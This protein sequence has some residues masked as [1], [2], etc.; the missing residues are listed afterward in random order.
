MPAHYLCGKNK[1][2]ITGRI[3][4]YYGFLKSKE[5][6]EKNYDLRGREEEEETIFCQLKNPHEAG[7]RLSLAGDICGVL[8]LGTYGQGF[9]ENFLFWKKE[10]SCMEVLA[11]PFQAVTFTPAWQRC[12]LPHVPTQHG[13]VYFRGYP[14]HLGTG[15]FPYQALKR[16][17]EW[18]HSTAS[19]LREMACRHHLGP[20]LPTAFSTPLHLKLWVPTGMHASSYPPCAEGTSRGRESDDSETAAW[21]AEPLKKAHAV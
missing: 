9:V 4:E 8:E 1:M 2:S 10:G 17:G 12:G 19:I 14:L 15:T 7:S 6:A 5:R 21:G 13:R 11:T 18:L 3:K 16:R 20:R